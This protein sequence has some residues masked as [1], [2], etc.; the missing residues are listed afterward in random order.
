MIASTE[1]ETG[2]TIFYSLFPPLSY[3]QIS[4]LKT[5]GPHF[6]SIFPDSHSDY[7][8]FRHPGS[9]PFGVFSSTCSG[10]LSLTLIPV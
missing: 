6:L 9:F 10:T 7:T 8:P 2:V 3:E 4:L 5:S 1:I